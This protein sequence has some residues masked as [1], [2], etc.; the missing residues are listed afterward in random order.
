LHAL[1]QRLRARGL[2]VYLE[3]HGLAVDALERVCGSLDVVSM[4]WKLA[5]DVRRE[6]DPKTGGVAPFHEQHQR[7]LEVATR[8]TE[9]FVKVVVTAHT[10]DAEIAE[11]CQRIAATAAATPLVLQPVTPF[12]KVRE[13][14]DAARLLALVRQC[15]EV[16]ETVR[17]VPQ[18]HKVYDAL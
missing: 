15:R 17:L 18:T 13:T 14:P 7:F 11:M 16:L 8:R 6:S 9:T 10:R 4:D 12:G 1:A 3:T 5:S 2:R